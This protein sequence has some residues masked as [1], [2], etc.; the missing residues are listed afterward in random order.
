MKDKN[1][2]G[3]SVNNRAE[4]SEYLTWF[5]KGNRHIQSVPVYS[6]YSHYFCIYNGRNLQ[7]MNL[8]NL[9]HS[10]ELNFNKER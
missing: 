10:S 6:C 9:A 2:T 3:M 4:I 8:S 1:W 7:M 5:S